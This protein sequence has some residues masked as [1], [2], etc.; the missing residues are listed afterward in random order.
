MLTQTDTYKGHVFPAGTTF[1]AN[2]WAIH[3]DENEFERPE[4]FSPDRWLGGNAYGT[5]H[6]SIASDQ[7]RKASYGWGGG[8]RI[9]SGQKMAERSL[10]IAMAKIVWALD[11]GA[12]EEGGGGRPDASV[13][14]AYRGGFWIC[15][16]RFP[17]EFNRGARL[18]QILYIGSIRG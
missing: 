7:R 18:M 3:H 1:F 16:K 6:S 4:I 17:T 5:K 9:C 10:K 11:F 13:E 15:P 8:R 12:G 14:T 2:T